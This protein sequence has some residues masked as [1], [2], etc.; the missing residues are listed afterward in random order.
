MSHTKQTLNYWWHFLQ[1]CPTC[2]GLF[3]ALPLSRDLNGIQGYDP[4]Y[5]WKSPDHS[6]LVTGP[7]H[8][9]VPHSL[10]ACMFL[11]YH[12]WG[13]L[14]RWQ[15]PYPAFIKYS[16]DLMQDEKEGVLNNMEKNTNHPQRQIWGYSVIE[17][18][19]MNSTLRSFVKIR[20][21][22]HIVDCG[23]SLTSSP[24]RPYRNCLLYLPSES[25]P[26]LYLI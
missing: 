1:L 16:S 11:D 6:P 23:H 21:S 13:I 12:G 18:L 17:I 9:L 8:S 15:D 5:L 4:S 22:S 2:I 20:L 24:S 14:Q 25:S 19:I 26:F 10:G 7:Y 3:Q